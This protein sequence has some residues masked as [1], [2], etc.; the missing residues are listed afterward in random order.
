MYFVLLVCRDDAYDGEVTGYEQWLEIT[1]EDVDTPD[2]RMALKNGKEFPVMM[3]FIAARPCTESGYREELTGAGFEIMEF[4][5]D[6][7][8]DSMR[9][10]ILVMK[11]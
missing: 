1:G 6:G 9:A 3:P 7:A 11:P 5:K 8:R 2:Q 4:K 10:D